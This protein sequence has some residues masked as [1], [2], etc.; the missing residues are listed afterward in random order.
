LKKNRTLRRQLEEEQKKIAG[1]G[2]EQGKDKLF[3]K[4]DVKKDNLEEENVEKKDIL[5]KV[6]T[7]RSKEKT[8]LRRAGQ[9]ENRHKQ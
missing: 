3:E 8:A 9:G 4:Q 5:E 6:R 1:R 2:E 7:R